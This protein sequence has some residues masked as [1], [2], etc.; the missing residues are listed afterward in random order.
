MR[1]NYLLFIIIALPFLL[2][3]CITTGIKEANPVGKVYRDSIQ[4][5]KN[6]TTS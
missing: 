1:K 6:H 5:W 4:L 2:M 3:G